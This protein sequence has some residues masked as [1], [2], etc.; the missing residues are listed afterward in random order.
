[1]VNSD[2]GD[3][4]L[5]D[6]TEAATLQP[7]KDGSYSA[8]DLSMAEAFLRAAFAIV[9]ADTSQD[10]ARDTIRNTV[11]RIESTNGKPI[12]PQLRSLLMRGIE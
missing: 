3:I 7:R 8:A 2:T 10:V 6:F 4:L 1:L 9:P 11:A 5:I 12:Q